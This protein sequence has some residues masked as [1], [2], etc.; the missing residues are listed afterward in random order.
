M[1]RV[2]AVIAATDDEA[3][4]SRFRDEMDTFSAI[5]KTSLGELRGSF[6]RTKA[7]FQSLVA[8]FGFKSKA[9]AGPTVQEFFDIWANFADAVSECWAAEHKAEVKRRFEEAQAVLRQQKELTRSKKVRNNKEGGVVA[10]VCVLSCCQFDSLTD[11][12][13]S[14]FAIGCIQADDGSSV[15]SRLK[16]RF[17]T[18]KT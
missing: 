8:R 10:T 14:L 5:G 3:R 15:A 17:S 7:L 4:G 6:D 1:K 13:V 9:P 11:C 16:K 18:T 12:W 2:E